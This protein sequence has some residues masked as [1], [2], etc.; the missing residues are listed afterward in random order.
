MAC[1]R[2]LEGA[3]NKSLAYFSHSYRWQNKA[4]NLQIWERL[5]EHFRFT[6]D[7]EDEDRPPMRI[8]CLEDM[9]RRS[10]AFIA[11]VPLR[12]E[13]PPLYCSP[14][15]VFENN[16]AIR[17]AK[18]RMLFI[19]KG[20]ETGLFHKRPKEI[21]TYDPDID[22]LERK[23]DRMERLI[24]KLLEQRQPVHD[25][26]AAEEGPVGILIPETGD[27]QVGTEVEH[28]VDQELRRTVMPID[29]TRLRNTSE[30]V[31]Q[32]KACSVVI[33]E[34][35]T[36]WT[37]QDILG[38]LNAYCVPLIRL[39]HL[40][41]SETVEHVSQQMRLSE[42][43]DIHVESND[44]NIPIIF[45][46]YQVGPEMEP[47]VFWRRPDDL[48]NPI[49][50]RLTQLRTK[51]KDLENHQEAIN[52]FLQ[53]GRIKGRVFISNDSSLN[54]L[55]VLLKLKLSEQGVECFHYSDKEMVDGGHPDFPSFLEKR[56]RGSVVFMAL[57]NQ[58]Y[59]ESEYCN[60]EVK[61]ALG[62]QRAGRM[63]I[64]PF[65][66]D[67]SGPPNIIGHVQGYPLYHTNKTA[68]DREESIGFIVSEVVKRLEVSERLNFEADE[69]M[70]LVRV[71]N[72]V[73]LERLKKLARAELKSTGISDA[74]LSKIFAEHIMTIDT[75]ER[76]LDRL[77]SWAR[78]SFEASNGLGRLI[79]LL[80][81]DPD[82]ERNIDHYWSMQE[83]LSRIV[84]AYQLL[85]DVRGYLSREETYCEFGIQRLSEGSI[86]ASFDGLENY[87][88]VNPEYTK[89]NLDS[90]LIVGLAEASHKYNDWQQLLKRIGSSLAELDVVLKNAVKVTQLTSFDGA[91]AR[92]DIGLCLYG[93]E[94][95]MEVPFEWYTRQNRAAPVCLEQPVRRFL[96]G[97]KKVREPVRKSL[98]QL[99]RPL[100][101]LIVGSD[102]G[103]IPMVEEESKDLQALFEKRF[104]EYNWPSNNIHVLTKKDVQAQRL[105]N[106]I[107]L[108]R[109]DILH[110]AAHGVLEDGQPGIHI[111]PTINDEPT[112]VAADQ[113]S[114]WVEKSTLRFVYLSICQG[115]TPASDTQ[116]K[117][118]R[119][120][121]LVQAF[122]KASVPEV[123]G[124]IWPIEDAKSRKFANVFYDRFL[125]NFRAAPALLSA[126][127][128]FKTD[129][130]IWAAPVLYSQCNTEDV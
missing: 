117:I 41:D 18:P 1:E 103:S 80:A 102:S 6:V 70:T 109:Y 50:H 88:P 35:R 125:N 119:F 54:D 101:A 129:D 67:R 127:L 78:Q 120:D 63:I 16:L 43:G 115:A 97:V 68:A 13:L 24:Q 82:V 42:A 77:I 56:I 89:D 27:R 92:E 81:F 60:A 5:K 10:E 105:E 59:H 49:K 30:L 104:N 3:M 118:R 126:R 29:P 116:Q 21:V 14:Y 91:I 108:G 122:V 85:P 48:W 69:R 44:A 90:E 76:L 75:P 83:S 100:R 40:E 74:K 110:I 15:Q 51:R 25:L 61:A 84:Q 98:I 95:G 33:V 39:F 114:M 12:K 62:E 26:D 2:D 87:K 53:L 34:T 72:V 96:I 106:E 64:L 121:N 71:F 19:E 4:L 22:W 7:P 57:I 111:C 123:V 58:P 9:M 124:F 65:L 66:F 32:I 79:N 73:E 55:A 46:G 11:V 23:S 52:Y 47:I 130:K 31:A 37:R 93:D 99:P 17:A 20:I 86:V 45:A 107:C 28:Y 8:C 128:K 113:F 38:M 94:K 112:F 36:S